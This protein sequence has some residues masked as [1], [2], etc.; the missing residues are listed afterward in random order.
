MRQILLIGALGCPALL[1]ACASSNGPPIGKASALPPAP[2]VRPA[3][4]APTHDWRALVVLPF[5]TL[6]KDVPYQL[7]EIVLFHGAGGGGR[8]DRECYALQ[9]AAMPRWFGLKVDEYSLC[10]SSDR[11]DRIEASVSLP[12]GSASSQFAAACADWRTAGAAGT[13]APDRCGGRDGTTE[14]DARLTASE[15]D[16]EPT[17]TI[18]LTDRAAAHDAGP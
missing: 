12:P 9:R 11:L 4:P 8:E 10:F 6:L 18:T 5:G 16:A 2:P 1:A 17:I 15:T 14:I 13:A 7:G 3:P